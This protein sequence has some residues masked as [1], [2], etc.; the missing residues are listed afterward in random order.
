LGGSGGP[1]A[2]S[3]VVG[4]GAGPANGGA[5]IAGFVLV[6][7]FDPVTGKTVTTRNYFYGEPRGGSAGSGNEQ[8]GYGGGPAIGPFPANRLSAGSSTSPGVNA[9]SITINAN[10]TFVNGT[11]HPNNELFGGGSVLA[12]GTGGSVTITGNL[13]TAGTVR[14][15]SVSIPDV[16]AGTVPATSVSSLPLTA[17]T[18]RTTLSI[19][20]LASVNAGH[21]FGTI[22]STDQTPEYISVRSNRSKSD[23]QPI[24]L[25]GQLAYIARNFEVSDGLGTILTLPNNN[26]LLFTSKD[27]IVST[28][29]GTISVA[30]GSALMIIQT[31]SEM[32]LVNLHDEHQGAVVL[33]IE[34]DKV[35]LPI[36]RQL[37]VTNNKTAN[38]DKVNISRIAYRE[39]REISLRNCKVFLSEISLPT[40][41]SMIEK[42]TGNNQNIRRLQKTA[43]ALWLMSLSQAKSPFKVAE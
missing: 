43:A 39:L 18:V 26:N 6:P 24:Q 7:V 21:P 22:V 14:A 4:N 42:T 1:G 38:F 40:A 20:S 27:G 29:F 10:N 35:D 15:S 2:S 13:V 41:L 25:V 23:V 16:K 3:D 33:D 5:E 34:G 28:P 31:A 37:I 30:A 17:T 8:F 36:G 19:P 32:A 11:V 9:G 12:L